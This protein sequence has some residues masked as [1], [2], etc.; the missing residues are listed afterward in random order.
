[1]PDLITVA[2]RITNLLELRTV[3]TAKKGPRVP[4]Q[5]SIVIIEITILLNARSGNCRGTNNSS[6][7]TTVKF[8]TRIYRNYWRLGKIEGLFGIDYVEGTSRV[9]LQSPHK[10]VLSFRIS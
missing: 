10:N 7:V 5:L 2:L 6:E 9:S 8:R 3:L 4:L 1:M